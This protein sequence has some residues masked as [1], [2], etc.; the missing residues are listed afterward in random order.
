MTATKSGSKSSIIGVLAPEEMRSYDSFLLSGQANALLFSRKD[1]VFLESRNG[2]FSLSL[3]ADGTFILQHGRER[4]ISLADRGSD[5]LAETF[6][7]VVTRAPDR[8]A[9]RFGLA[10]LITLFGRSL[11]QR[12][13][14]LKSADADDSDVVSMRKELEWLSWLV[15][16][17][18]SENSFLRGASEADL[19]RNAVCKFARRAEQE[20]ISAALEREPS[21]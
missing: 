9:Q 20:S 6:E 13:D 1:K 3:S 4:L 17:V 14:K 12:V 11:E 21:E 10:F 5:S 15:R 8:R 2:L 7:Q 18:L 16:A 19:A